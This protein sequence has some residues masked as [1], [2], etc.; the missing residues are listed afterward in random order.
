[1]LRSIASPQVDDTSYLRAS[2]FAK[3]LA[4]TA[5]EYVYVGNMY[6]NTRPDRDWT[7]HWFVSEQAW[8]RDGYGHRVARMRWHMFPPTYICAHR[9]PMYA[10]RAGYAISTDIV[11]ELLKQGDAPTVILPNVEDACMG[12]WIEH[13][14]KVWAFKLRSASVIMLFCCRACQSSM[15]TCQP[16][17]HGAAKT[18][19]LSAITSH[20]TPCCAC[21]SSEANAVMIMHQLSD[22]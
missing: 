20:R 6:N 11:R 17:H 3:V 13:V 18:V 1:M 16:F 15:W 22:G 9:Y 8:Q 4:S 10:H 7:S 5:H 12:I 19:T 2:M 21:S 14:A